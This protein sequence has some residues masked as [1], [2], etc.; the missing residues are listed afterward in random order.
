MK[1][2][3]L[4]NFLE[5]QDPDSLV[6]VDGYEGNYNTPSTI[7]EITICGPFED[8]QW[9]MGRYKDHVRDKKQT[10]IKAIYLPRH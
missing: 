6:V 10:P 5:T 9:Y 7:K 3:E 2:K 4:I 8:T 1:V